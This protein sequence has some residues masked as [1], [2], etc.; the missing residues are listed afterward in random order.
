MKLF[1]FYLSLL[2]LFPGAFTTK[3]AVQSQP[4]DTPSG[5]TIRT[6][7]LYILGIAQ[8]AGYPQAGCEKQCC[9]R[10][11]NNPEQQRLVTS[12]ALVAPSKQHYMLFEA[13]PDIKT[14]LHHLNTTYPGYK[15]MGIFLTHGHIGHYA[16]LMQLGREAMGAMTVNV[17]AMP[18]MADFLFNNGPWSSLIRFHHIQVHEM[19]DSARIHL[20]DHYKIFPFTVPHR[21]EYTETVGFQING[22]NRKAVFIPDI[23]KWEKWQHNIVDVVKAN[24]VVLIDGTFFQNGELPHR[25]MSEIPHPFMEETMALLKELPAKEKAKVYFIHF[26]H[27]NPVLN[28]GSDARK[29]VLDAGFRL[30]EEGMVIEL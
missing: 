17:F 26:N 21:D 3:A 10:A 23:D 16:G 13:T 11:W 30:A 7:H 29:Q 28:P 4:N 12:L 25:D 9:T 14:Q 18:R 5:D 15:M 19:K 2:L 20:K 6:P 1:A 27:T 22:P 8:D 24:D